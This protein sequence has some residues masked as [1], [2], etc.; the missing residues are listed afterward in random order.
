[1]CHIHIRNNKLIIKTQEKRQTRQCSLWHASITENIHQVHISSTEEKN[2]QLMV[3]LVNEA[4][5]SQTTMLHT[6]LSLLSRL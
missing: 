6:K 1:M 3:H 4:F 5:H 2:T